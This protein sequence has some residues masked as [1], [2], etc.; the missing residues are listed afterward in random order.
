M[1]KQRVNYSS[2]HQLTGLHQNDLVHL[3]TPLR[4]LYFLT[5]AKLPNRLKDSFISNNCSK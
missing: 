4:S 5:D 1:T 2:G 3:T